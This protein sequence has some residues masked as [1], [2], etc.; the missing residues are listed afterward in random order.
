MKGEVKKNQAFRNSAK[1][2]LGYG[3][4]AIGLSQLKIAACKPPQLLLIP[5]PN[6]FAH[7]DSYSRT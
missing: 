4:L 1:P 6:S 7:I 5:D 2:L 3:T